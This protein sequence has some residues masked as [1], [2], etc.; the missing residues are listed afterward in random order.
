MSHARPPA[1]ALVVLAAL[2][3]LTALVAGCHRHGVPGPR[4]ADERGE[5]RLER[6]ARRDLDCGE[7]RLLA[8]R[9]AAYQVDGCGR[10]AEYAYVC[11]GRR[12][13]WVS[14]E[15]AVRHAERDLGCTRELL[16]GSAPAPTQRDF[17][18][19]GRAISYSLECNTVSCDWQ[20][21]VTRGPA[22][23]AGAT[24]GA[25]SLE[26]VAVPPAPGAP[27]ASA[28]PIEL[29]LELAIPAPARAASAV[30]AGDLAVPPPPR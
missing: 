26:T 8:L 22:A 4:A 13:E 15:A 7:V 21:F 6:L 3:A 30:P 11:T 9:D 23:S 5:R 28:A 2:A 10:L 20:L 14:I 27:A 18:G 29:E 12:C 17:V 25:G 24:P 19:C 16:S 1:C